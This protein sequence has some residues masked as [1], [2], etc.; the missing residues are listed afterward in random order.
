VVAVSGQA[1]AL[2]GDGGGGD[3]GGGVGQESGVLRDKALLGLEVGRAGGGKGRGEGRG[4]GER[5]SG[6]T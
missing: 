5:R 3:R 2:A 4:G 1:V 6:R